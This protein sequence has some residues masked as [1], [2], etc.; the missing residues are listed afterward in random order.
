MDKL[1]DVIQE[2]KSD[3]LQQYVMTE[4]EGTPKQEPC[5]WIQEK[6]EREGLTCD[7][8]TFDGAIYCSSHEICAVRR[9]VKEQKKADKE[10]REFKEKPIKFYIKEDR[11]DDNVPI[12]E[13]KPIKIETPPVPIKQSEPTKI[14]NMDIT[15]TVKLL[16]SNSSPNTP[17]RPQISNEEALI[18]LKDFLSIMNRL[19]EILYK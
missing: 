14:E 9:N 1:Q 17:A 15:A 4:P 6:G 19:T 13:I 16:E 7:K 8:P 18:I 2:S 5:P 12:I 10:G 11:K 3:L